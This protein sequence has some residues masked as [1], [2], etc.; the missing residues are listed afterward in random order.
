M[1]IVVIVVR[2]NISNGQIYPNLMILMAY[3][4]QQWFTVVIP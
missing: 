2:I 3:N 4:G 1:S